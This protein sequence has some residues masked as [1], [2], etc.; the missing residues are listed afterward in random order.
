MTDELSPEVVYCPKD[1]IIITK[2]IKEVVIWNEPQFK[3]NSNHPPTIKCNHQS[4]TE[5]YWG[6]WNVSCTA[7]DNNPNNKPAL[8]QFNIT[9]KRK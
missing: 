6:T 3:D 7:R 5:F 4:G 2:E 9:V 1:Q 8:C